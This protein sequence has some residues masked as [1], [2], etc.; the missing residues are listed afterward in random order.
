VTTQCPPLRQSRDTFG[1][2]YKLKI[3]K[4]GANLYFTVYNWLILTLVLATLAIFS[5][6]LQILGRICEHKHGI[7]SEKFIGYKGGLLEYFISPAESMLYIT[8][9]GVKKAKLQ[10]AS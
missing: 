5:D 3:I 9:H 2:I 10:E 6:F 7:Y 1:G 4:V 8:E